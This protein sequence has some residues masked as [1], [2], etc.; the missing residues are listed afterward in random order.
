MKLYEE[1]KVKRNVVTWNRKRNLKLGGELAKGGVK[2][3]IRKNCPGCG[4]PSYSGTDAGEWICPHCGKDL[5]GEP[6]K[7]AADSGEEENRERRVQE[8]EGRLFYLLDKVF[9]NRVEEA[10]GRAAKSRRY[11]EICREIGALERESNVKEQLGKVYFKLDDLQAEKND[12]K[13]QEIYL[14]GIRDGY[15]VAAFLSRTYEPCYSKQYEL[16]RQ[17]AEET[18]E[19][20]PIV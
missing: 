4:K 10:V 14:Q 9:S 6:V 13:E 12:I 17:E 15:Q 20:R 19:D 5:T 16:A 7:P 1:P 3:V 18:E 2:V 11:R 8:M